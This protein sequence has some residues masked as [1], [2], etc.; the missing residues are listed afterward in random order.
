MVLSIV[1]YL[2]LAFLDVALLAL[3]PLFFA[4]P[5]SLGGMGMSP[6]TIGLCLGIFG[7]M[8]GVAHGLFFPKVIQRVGL[9][10]LFLTS[11]FCFI[12]MFAM[13]PVV[14]HFAREW[15][16]SPAVWGLI[17]FHFVISS[18][19]EMAF[20]GCSLLRCVDVVH[21][22]PV[23]SPPGCAFLYITSSVENS[24]VLGSVHGIGQ[25]GASLTRALGPAVATSLFAFTLENNWLGGLG[26]YVV[27]IAI[28]LCAMPLA[29]QLPEKEW[30]HTR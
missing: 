7:L 18:A 8:D 30:E 4:T 20:G 6:A 1:N 14:N 13:F 10:K 2:W 21:T 16:L 23:P 28:S 3:H 15:G 27:L 19:T 11:V 26:V 12:P 24:R 17:I 9:K 29:Y 22:T 25:T 5:I